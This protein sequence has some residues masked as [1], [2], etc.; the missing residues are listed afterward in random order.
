MNAL[1]PRTAAG[2]SL[3]FAL[4]FCESFAFV[5]LP[6]SRDHALSCLPPLVADDD[7]AHGRARGGRSKRGNDATTYS[8]RTRRRAPGRRRTAAAA[9]ALSGLPDPRRRA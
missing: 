8:G 2:L 7:D 5:S 9:N 4:A 1:L 3:V 6:L